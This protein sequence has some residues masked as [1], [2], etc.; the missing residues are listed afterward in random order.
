MRGSAGMATPGRDSA[1]SRADT[2]RR[3]FGAEL[4]AQRL[5]RGVAL[6]HIARATNVPV[7]LWEELEEGALS[8][9]PRGVQARGWVADYARLVA[10]DQQETVDAFCRTFPEGDRR[11]TG[12]V[13]DLAGTLGHQPTVWTGDWPRE[14][15]RAPMIRLRDAKVVARRE[16]IVATAFD[17][18]IATLLGLLVSA[19][20]GM[21]LPI[22]I[23]VSGM[24][25]FAVSAGTPLPLSVRIS[26]YLL[27]RRAGS[28]LDADAARP[29]ADSQ[30]G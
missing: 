27:G 12:I 11:R 3:E 29:V 26:R 9:W 22:A 6:D 10:L 25:Y 21:R 4:R 7:V 24:V 13:G 19:V 20:T 28:T 14:E 18:I 30:N 1:A 17:V 15:R 2:V 8:N 16:R 5:H 23:L